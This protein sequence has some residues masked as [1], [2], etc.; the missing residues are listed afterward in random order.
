MVS[1][2]DSVL[3]VQEHKFSSW[4]GNQDATSFRD[5]AKNNNNNNKF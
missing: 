1:G 5:A 2:W 3:P 4:S